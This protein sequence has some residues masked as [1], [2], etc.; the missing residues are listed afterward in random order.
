MEKEIAAEKEAHPSSTAASP[1][2]EVQQIDQHVLPTACR[3]PRGRHQRGES[4]VFH[5]GHRGSVHGNNSSVHLV[6]G[7]T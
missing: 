5:I 6:C 4:G 7:K 3:L 1:G 2:Q